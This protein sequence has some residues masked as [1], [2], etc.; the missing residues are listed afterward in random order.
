MKKAILVT[1]VID[2]DNSYPLTYSS[3]RSFFSNEERLRQTIFTLTSLDLV[4]DNDTTIFLVD[5]SEN[6][7]H[8]K[9]LLGYQRNIVYVDVRKEFPDVYNLIKTHPHKS[10]CEVTL[11]L[12]FYNRYKDILKDYDFL[13]K[14]SGRYFFDSNFNFNL[15]VEENKDKFFFKHPITFDWSDNWGYSMVDRRSV[16]GDN[17]LRQYSSVLYGWGQNNHERMLDIYRG[18]SEFTR[19]PNTYHY[20]VETLLYFFTRQYEENIIETDWKV[21]GW[22]GVD[23]TF[24]RY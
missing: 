17:K 1:S 6:S 4:M 24:L 20:D 7:D 19:N 3:T 15:C 14:L 13:F 9:S 23:G 22:T 10:Y 18:I 12:N 11:Q 2:I 16:Q 5:A 8:Y 21:L